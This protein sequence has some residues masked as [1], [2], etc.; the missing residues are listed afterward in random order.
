MI[1]AH[2]GPPTGRIG[3][4]AG[5]LHQLKSAA[6]ADPRPRHDVRFPEPSAGGGRPSKLSTT[7]SLS[8]LTRVR[9]KVFGPK[10]YRPPAGDLEQ[11]GGV[12]DR[13]MRELTRDV[14]ADTKSS[15]TAALA[16]ADIV[17]T[18][19]SFSTESALDERRPGQRVWMMC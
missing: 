12:V 8:L 6:L 11:A 14:R 13:M 16:A 15:L 17:F 10:F 9:R 4:P 19:D 18:H 2:V 3:G 5:Y 7:P 1:V